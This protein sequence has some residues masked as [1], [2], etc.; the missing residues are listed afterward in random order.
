MKLAR[1]RSYPCVW[2]TVLAALLL[3]SASASAGTFS[4]TAARDSGAIQARAEAAQFL[5]YATFGPT[6]NDIDALAGRI[7][8]VG[9]QRALEE[10]IDTQFAVPATYH[11]ALARQMVEA[12]GFAPDRDD[13]G[14]SRYRDYAWR[15][16]AIAAKD[17]LRQR[18]AWALAQIFVVN[19][20][21]ERFN[22]A[23]IDASGEP[24]WL[25]LPDYYD[26]LVRNAFGSYRDVL[27][28][29]TLHP[30]MGVFLSHVNNSKGDTSLGLFPDENYAR[31]VMQLF[32]IGLY[33]L[34]AD[35]TSRRNA[36]GEYLETYD[37][38]D[39]ESMARVFTGL[40]FAGEYRFRARKNYLQA[41]QMIEE[42]HDKGEKILF[43]GTV[44]PAGQTGM[45]DVHM[46]LDHLFYHDNVGPFLAQRLIQRFVKSNPSGSY[47]KRVADAFADNSQGVRGDFKAVIK[48]VLLDPE[49]WASQVYTPV[50]TPSGLRITPASIEDTRL[51][52]PV[53]RYTA[54]IR[55]FN[56]SSDHPSG[57]FLVP[58]N[59]SVMNQAPYRAPSVFNFYRPD[60][61]AVS[62]S[63]NQERPTLSAVPA[64]GA[65]DS[66]E[67]DGFSLGG[68]DNSYGR[69]SGATTGTRAGVIDDG[70]SLG[71][72]DNSFGRLK[73]TTNGAPA[74]APSEYNRTFSPRDTSASATL[75]GPEFAILTSPAINKFANLLRRHVESGAA[76]Y[77]LKNNDWLGEIRSKVTFDFRREIELAGD[78]AA[79]MEHLDLLLC[80]G[81]MSDRVKLIIQQVIAS[82]TEENLERAS[83]AIL[84][85]LTSTECSV[86]N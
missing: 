41:M 67:D 78:P 33:E 13:I 49:V 79:L 80:H 63:A 19:E 27:G 50:K 81:T 69:V 58:S 9:R 42:E 18:M 56:P 29:V 23:D 54:F 43:D 24:R 16:A 8:R 11:K 74:F 82:E 15:H 4:T 38:D 48:A 26:V 14:V 60:Y 47:I 73:S 64:T 70:L 72:Y 36:R 21:G 22:N 25:G 62:G 77:I 51:R 31:E 46:A 61:Q 84:A 1:L 75:W 44:L 5:S 71:G 68:Y 65:Y 32:S 3:L 34:N 59:Y 28:E 45:Q 55:A 57:R 66:S 86:S 40:T 10:W 52:E 53:I 7:A 12:D 76:T 6:I 39:I 37:N 83:G 2:S 20:S 30:V 85:T 17:Q 35:G